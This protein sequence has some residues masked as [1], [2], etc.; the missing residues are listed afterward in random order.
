MPP[1]RKAFERLIA[2]CLVFE[3]A[4]DGDVRGILEHEIL[5]WVLSTLILYSA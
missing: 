2:N 5:V 3:K 1:D 4:A